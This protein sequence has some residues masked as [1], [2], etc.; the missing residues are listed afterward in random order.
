MSAEVAR[1][2]RQREDER[3]FLRGLQPEPANINFTSKAPAEV[4]QQQRD[5]AADT[6]KQTQAI[7]E[8]LRGLC[9]A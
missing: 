5:R 8:D 6:E 3:K 7:V 2:E 4:V 1:P 9:R